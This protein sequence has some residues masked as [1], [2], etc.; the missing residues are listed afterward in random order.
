MRENYNN[1]NE[2]ERK[3]YETNKDFT[4]NK[5][6][7]TFNEQDHTLGI[8]LT[9][10]FFILIGIFGI[11]TA[12]KSKAECSTFDQTAILKYVDGHAEKNIGQHVE[13]FSAAPTS[14]ISFKLHGVTEL[15]EDWEVTPK[16][17]VEEVT[18]IQNGDDIVVFY[19]VTGIAPE[20]V[21]ACSK[22]LGIQF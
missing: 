14:T 8:I 4:A 10:I 3:K 16:E 12:P 5:D 7:S 2:K 20:S 17:F 1:W 6:S 13:S 18:Q 9:A 21:T 22:S 15:P 11:L 19:N